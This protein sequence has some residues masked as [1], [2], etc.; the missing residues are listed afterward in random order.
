MRFLPDN[1][2]I[3]ELVQSPGCWFWTGH[4]FKR[5]D[6]VTV[7]QTD[8]N[9]LLRQF[10]H[11]TDVPKKH[12]TFPVYNDDVPVVRYT[13]DFHDVL[14]CT[15]NV[16]WV[17]NTPELRGSVGLLDSLTPTIH[18]RTD[19]KDHDLENIQSDADIPGIV[20]ALEDNEENIDAI[21]MHHTF[22]N[23]SALFANIVSWYR[24]RAHILV[25]LRTRK[26]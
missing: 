26:M 22:S 23:H 15:P 8:G 11:M 2:V 21:T 1:S 9:R 3:E 16:S 24:G 18:I 7:S 6:E 19:Y 12:Q 13:K 5:N 20:V 25:C 17:R 4:E 10:I 14:L